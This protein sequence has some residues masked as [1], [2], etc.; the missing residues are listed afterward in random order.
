MYKT[1]LENSLNKYKK[2]S[3]KDKKKK[4]RKVKIFLSNNEHSIKITNK[5][6]NKNYVK[7]A[8]EFLKKVK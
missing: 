2:L 8:K 5:S 6:Y 3:N 4:V 1:I 7:A